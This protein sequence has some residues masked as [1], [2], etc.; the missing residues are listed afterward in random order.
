MLHGSSKYTFGQ[1][2]VSWGTKDRP[3]FGLGVDVHVKAPGALND[4]RKLAQDHAACLR[5]STVT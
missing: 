5:T 1:R 4:R 3:A 2:E